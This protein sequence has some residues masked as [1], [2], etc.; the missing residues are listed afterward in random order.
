M[1]VEGTFQVEKLYGK[2]CLVPFDIPTIEAMKGVSKNELVRG[3]FSGSKKG[4][5]LPQFGLYWACC[6]LVAGNTENQEMNTKEKVSEYVKLKIGWT[7]FR[8]VYS[9]GTVHIKTKTLSHD[10]IDH[11]I[12]DNYFSQALEV[13]AGFLKIT[14]EQLVFNAKDRMRG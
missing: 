4:V 3:K 7:D 12:F 11:F 10:N 14:P 2:D 13:M 9:D 6:A 5:S 8:Q 1:K